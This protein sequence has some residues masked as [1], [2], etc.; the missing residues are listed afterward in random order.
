M[1][2]KFTLLLMFC[3]VICPGQTPPEKA[4]PN[5]YITYAEV[6]AML[7]KGNNSYTYPKQP[8]SYADQLEPAISYL[9]FPDGFYNIYENKTRNYLIA[10]GTIINE[11][12]TGTWHYYYPNKCI[13]RSYTYPNPQANDTVNVK[14][15]NH[16]GEVYADLKYRHDVLC[17][18]QIYYG[19]YLYNSPQTSYDS[20]YYT[21]KSGYEIYNGSRTP[22]ECNLS[23]WNDDYD[24]DY[25]YGEARIVK[26]KDSTTYRN[27]QGVPMLRIIHNIKPGVTPYH[28]IVKNEVWKIELSS[29]NG[30]KLRCEFNNRNQTYDSTYSINEFIS[31]RPFQEYKN[32]SKLIISFLATDTANMNKLLKNISGTQHLEHLEDIIILPSLNY[33]PPFVYDCKHLKSLHISYFTGDWDNEKMNCLSQLETFSAGVNTSLAADKLLKQLGQLPNLKVLS[34]GESH[35]W[36]KLKNLHLLRNLTRLSLHPVVNNKDMFTTNI[37]IP[38]DVFGLKHLVYFTNSYGGNYFYASYRKMLK[39]LPNCLYTPFALG[40]LEA[41]TNILLAKDTAVKIEDIKVGDIVLAYDHNTNTIDTSLVTK[42]FIHRNNNM[43]CLEL[44]VQTKDSLI[45]IGTTGNHPFFIGGNETIN[46]GGIKLTDKLM[47]TDA[48]RH[49]SRPAVQKIVRLKQNYH[50]VYNIETTKHNYFA[51]GI[52]VHNK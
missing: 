3:Y 10:R 48:S 20:P 50:T 5:I 23:V 38:K 34:L 2:L 4:L 36:H 11:K 22:L 44:Y 37:K 40:C 27:E 49:I 6:Q 15:Y 42:T 26:N 47:F 51:N 21:K 35:E 16:L 31:R 9:H 52:L 8:W 32:L 28:P 30:D 19:A 14:V 41:G 12:Q 25:S 33:I 29:L 18:K 46:A 7:R 45:K 24:D 39:K 13:S 1:P 17:G 43:S